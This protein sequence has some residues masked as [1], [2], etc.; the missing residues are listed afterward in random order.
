MR[1]FKFLLV[2]ISFKNQKD[3]NRRT[4]YICL[5]FTFTLSL[6]SIYLDSIAFL[7]PSSFSISS[8]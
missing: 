3:I 5:Q 7:Y 8:T 6:L 2:Y 4:I 1:L